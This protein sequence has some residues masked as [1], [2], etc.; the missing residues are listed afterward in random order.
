M[1]ARDIKGEDLSS[2]LFWQRARV[3]DHVQR[4]SQT[5]ELTPDIIGGAIFGLE[6]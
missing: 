4:E 5:V 6:P 2:R 1:R 3:A